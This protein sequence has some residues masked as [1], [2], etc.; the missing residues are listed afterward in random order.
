MIMAILDGNEKQID[1]LCYLDERIIDTNWKDYNSRKRL[2]LTVYRDYVDIMRDLLHYGVEVNSR[3]KDSYERELQYL[4]PY[5]QRL[6]VQIPVSIPISRR[7]TI[8][9]LA[10]RVAREPFD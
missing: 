3:D 7:V 1:Y 6:L 4:A 8:R 5:S 10:S 9:Q 2:S